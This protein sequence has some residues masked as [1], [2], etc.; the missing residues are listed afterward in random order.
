MVNDYIYSHISV[1]VN[2]KILDT[3][4]RMVASLKYVEMLTGRDLS[5]QI[6]EIKKRTRI[7]MYNTNTVDKGYQDLTSFLNHLRSVMN[8]GVI[9]ARPILMAKELTV[10]RLKNYMHTG[11]GYFAN[12]N[13]TMKA[14]AKAESIVFGEGVFGD[15]INK[16]SGKMK[17]GDRSKVE[18]LNSQ[19]EFFK[20]LIWVQRGL[21]SVNWTKA[22]T[23]AKNFFSASGIPSLS[24]VSL[25]A[26]GTSSQSFSTPLLD[27][28]KYV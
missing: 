24:N 16:L 26:S 18:A 12:D 11:F 17:P 10:G 20:E 9:A 22:S 23:P 8:F 7:S 2:Q 5:D 1:N 6:E 15:K 19:Y 27:L 14:I 28:I 13:I 25:I 21:V 3:T 4:D